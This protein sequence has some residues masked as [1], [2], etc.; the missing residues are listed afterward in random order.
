MLKEAQLLINDPLW[1]VGTALYWG[2]GGKTQQLVRISNSD[3]F[4]LKIMMR[5]F[6]EICNVPMSKFR[7][8]VHAYQHSEVSKIEA[9]WSNITNIPVSSVFKTYTKPSSASKHKRN[10]FTEWHYWYICPGHKF[11][12]AHYG[13][14][15]ILKRNKI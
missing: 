9:Y 12:L 1:C 7:G 11:I 13:M 8:H 15:R 3:A 4:V 2:E 14:D 10:T 5:Y 6:I